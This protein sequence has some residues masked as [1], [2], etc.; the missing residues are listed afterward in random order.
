MEILNNIWTAL[1][2]ENITLINILSVP[3]SFIEVLVSMLL[4][5]S[6]LNINSNKKQRIIYL[7]IASIMA[8]VCSMFIP[9]P[10]SNIIT[11]I[12]VPITVI[13]IFKV[14][15]FKGILAEFLP[16]ICI[17]IIELIVSRIRLAFFNMDYTVS[18]NIPLS[19]LIINLSIYALL[20]LLYLLIKKIQ[21]NINIFD[22]ITK[23][24]KY[25]IL[26]NVIIAIIVVF[27]Q[28]YLIVYYNDKLPLFIILINILSLVAYFG[29]SIFSLTKTMKLEQTSEDLEQQKLYNKTLQILHDNIRA[30]KHDFANIIAGIGGYIETDDLP[31]L[32]KYYAQLLEDCNQVNNLSSLSPDSVNN[33]A[34]YAVLA[35]KY[36][37]ADS[38][39]IKIN[40]ET[41]IDFNNLHMDIYEFTRILGILMDN[42]IEASSECEEKIINVTIRD[43]ETR[44]RQL[45]TI[46][47]TYKNKDVDVNKIYEKGYSTKANNTGLGL[48][49]VDKIIKKHKNITRFTAKT[50]ELFKQQIEIYNE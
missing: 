48:W 6:I 17:T 4:F 40:L 49:E 23:K 41:F 39:G 7:I 50:E 16:I 31:G 27:V 19:R 5:L 20:F 38:L 3:L 10:Y 43:E 25:I 35:N 11:I 30:F 28:I 15:I 26:S 18:A 14:S 44:N 46:E 2:T 36:Y 29:I 24:N 37:K 33:P 42:A 12:A 34:V 32:K 21:F 8:I 1:T 9:K 13:L 47:N 45:L 22:K